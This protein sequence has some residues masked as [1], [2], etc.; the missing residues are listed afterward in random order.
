M[1]S[2]FPC[3]SPLTLVPQEGK[4]RGL[5]CAFVDKPDHVLCVIDS[6]GL[7]D[8]GKRDRTATFDG[9][10]MS[11]LVMACSSL[12]VNIKTNITESDLDR[13]ACFTRMAKMIAGDLN[14]IR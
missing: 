12:V 11:I 7:A 4:T 5:W 3:A 13:L 10:L 2:A 14:T 1:N 9:Q 8:A 6:E